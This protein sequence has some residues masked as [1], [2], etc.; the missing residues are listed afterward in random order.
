[1]HNFTF[2]PAR[3]EVGEQSGIN[4]SPPSKRRKLSKPKGMLDSIQS[5]GPTGLKGK[6]PP[7]PL[8]EQ[9]RYSP[10]TIEQ[11]SEG[12]P[13]NTVLPKL[14]NFVDEL[15]PATAR[16]PLALTDT[17]WAFRRSEIAQ[18]NPHI[19]RL[20]L[21]AQ[22]SKVELFKVFEVFGQSVC[23]EVMDKY[24][25]IEKEVILRSGSRA[26][27]CES[28]FAF[29]I[30]ENFVWRMTNW[31]NICLGRAQQWQPFHLVE[32]KCAAWPFGEPMTMEVL[33]SRNRERL[34]CIFGKPPED[35]EIPWP[36]CEMRYLLKYIFG[37]HEYNHIKRILNPNI[38]GTP[39]RLLSRR[40]QIAE[41]LMDNCVDY[42]L[43]RDSLSLE[44]GLGPFKQ[45][46]EKFL[47]NIEIK[48]FLLSS[49]QFVNHREIVD[50]ATAVY[51][52]HTTWEA[53][54]Q[55]LLATQRR[56]STDIFRDSPRR[57][58][59]RGNRIEWDFNAELETDAQN[60]WDSRYMA[61]VKKRPP[62]PSEGEPKEP[63]ARVLIAVPQD[64]H[65][66]LVRVADTPYRRGAVAFETMSVARKID[67]LNLMLTRIANSL[68][69]TDFEHRIST[70]DWDLVL[71]ALRFNL[72]D[73]YYRVHETVRMPNLPGERR[74]ENQPPLSRLE[75]VT[76]VE[77]FLSNNFP[78]LPDEIPA[79]GLE[80][81]LPQTGFVLEEEE[82]VRRAKERIY[83][84]HQVHQH[85]YIH[86]SEL[87]NLLVPEDIAPVIES[88][89]P[90]VEE[91]LE[92]M[93]SPASPPHDIGDGGGEEQVLVSN[94]DIA[95]QEVIEAGLV[96][97]HRPTSQANGTR[98]GEGDHPG[99]L[100]C[101][102][103]RRE[104]NNTCDMCKARGLCD[105]CEKEKEY[106]TTCAPIFASY[107][108]IPFRDCISCTSSTQHWCSNCEKDG[109][110]YFLGVQMG[111]P[112]CHRC[113]SDHPYCPVCSPDR[114]RP[115]NSS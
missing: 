83:N 28:M 70:W 111:R 6:I 10:I 77:R 51:F 59:A 64:R 31:A 54:V 45:E 2:C 106:C 15:L 4:L 24:D 113:F 80:E 94:I 79:R 9:G 62:D 49:D 47:H 65:A 20:K 13:M 74:E 76:M 75:K 38:L 12:S 58:I 35:P 105:I 14:R 95:M 104:T 33:L 68:P 53:E 109:E 103:C 21:L 97:E 34:D 87:A 84:T 96:A 40:V 27:A 32:N 112:Y 52:G 3:H 60:L 43:V 67:F 37:D 100:L 78:V 55:T 57:N 16:L 23:E 8:D 110:K 36:S 107:E 56:A 85:S 92:P 89:R 98:F 86:V 7:P 39:N 41:A 1:M 66:T 88:P 17:F 25:S 72:Y 22:C 99:P 108:N 93:Y 90:R 69:R 73:L 30:S 18:E 91:S 63:N 5:G 48:I 50:I 11:I 26:D 19:K 114:K 44:Y 71:N 61:G 42:A 82:L 81:D 101:D 102:Q 46:D 115:L 29:F